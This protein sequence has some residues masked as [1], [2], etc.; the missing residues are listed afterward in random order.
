MNKR[1][2]AAECATIPILI[3][4]IFIGSS[5]MLSDSWVQCR[6]HGD[7]PKSS[8]WHNKNVDGTWCYKSQANSQ[9]ETLV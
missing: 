7:G 6:G 8:P 4:V 2:S 9:A 1:E 5:L 3:N